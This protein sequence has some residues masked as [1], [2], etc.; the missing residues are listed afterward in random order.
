MSAD[1][2]TDKA[3]AAEERL[4]VDD[5]T[6]YR[7]SGEHT[8]YEAT[9]DLWIQNGNQ[10]YDKL[11]RPPSKVAV[12]LGHGDND[13]CEVLADDQTDSLGQL[14]RAVFHLTAARNQLAAMLASGALASMPAP[15][16]VDDLSAVAAAA[17]VKASDVLAAMETADTERTA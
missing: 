10:D 4:S 16:T 15:R 6:I 9:G 5:F 17:G 12:I 1:Q 7:D 11:A 2:P 8:A 3:R 14:D 13:F